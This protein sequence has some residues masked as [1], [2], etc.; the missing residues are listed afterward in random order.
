MSVFTFLLSSIHHF[1]CAGNVQAV[2]MTALCIQRRISP[3]RVPNSSFIASST[4]LDHSPR[5]SMMMLYRRMS[6]P[7]NYCLSSHRRGPYL[8]VFSSCFF[9]LF[10]VHGQ[11][12]S[13]ART[14]F[15]S[16]SINHSV[17]PHML[18]YCKDWNIQ[19]SLGLG[20]LV[21]GFE[22][23]R[24]IPALWRERYLFCVCAEQLASTWGMLSEVLP[25]IWLF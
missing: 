11:L 24:R 14:L 15:F 18:T 25:K 9:S 4:S 20:W 6:Y 5:T 12:I 19:I 23:D 8:V 17:L 10:S 22:N 1:Q 3:L 2:Q 7:G 21:N 13:T 16:W